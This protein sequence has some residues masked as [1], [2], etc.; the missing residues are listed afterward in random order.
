MRTLT[1]VAVALVVVLAGC[2]GLPLPGSE[3]DRVSVTPADVPNRAGSEAMPPGVTETGIVDPIRLIDAHRGVVANETLTVTER[4]QTVSPNGTE[5]SRVNTTYRFS[6]NRTL[7]LVETTGNSTTESDIQQ[8]IW[9]NDTTRYRL[10]HSDGMTAYERRPQA[11]L[12]SFMYDKF[13]ERVRSVENGT[14]TTNDSAPPR[15]RLNGSLKGK[16]ARAFAGTTRRDRTA[17]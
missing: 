7:T 13:Q 2:S 15:Y 12:Q 10:S 17:I 16:T 3:S 5:L 14:V 6:A 1:P 9:Q 11:D 8:S 4:W